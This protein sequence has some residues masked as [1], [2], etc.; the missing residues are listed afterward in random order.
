MKLS[1]ICIIIY[2]FKSIALSED[3]NQFYITVDGSLYDD[4]HGHLTPLNPS[5]I[6]AAKTSI[7]SRP[8]RTFPEG[9]WGNPI[10]GLQASLRLSKLTYTNGEIVRAIVLIRNVTNTIVQYSDINRGLGDDPVRLIV[11]TKAGQLLPCANGSRVASL[12]R[13]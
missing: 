10:C 2:I 6:Q 12:G 11:K 7:E 9:N 8:A 3:T 4:G 5:A 13:R 1:L